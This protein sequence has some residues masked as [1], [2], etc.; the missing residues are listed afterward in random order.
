MTK[1]YKQILKPTSTPGEYTM[2]YVE[3]TLSKA[4]EDEIKALKDAKAA[5]DLIL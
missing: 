2:V 1:Q 5:E 3:E 4:V